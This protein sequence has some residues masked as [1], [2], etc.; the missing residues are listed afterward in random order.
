MPIGRSHPR[1]FRSYRDSILFRLRFGLLQSGFP[2]GGKFRFHAVP[3]LAFKPRKDQRR[4]DND[5]HK[6][7]RDQRVQRPDAEDRAFGLRH[8]RAVAR[9][10]ESS[11][12]EH[13]TGDKRSHAL[14]ELGED[15][16]RDGVRRALHSGESLIF[17]I[18]KDID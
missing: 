16:G 9:G 15:T 4:R 13:D 12:L 17:G 18:V 2:A 3:H 7:Q 14:S 5:Q 8:D 10:K 11:R 1:V 6:E